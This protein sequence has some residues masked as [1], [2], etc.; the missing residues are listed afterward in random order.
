LAGGVAHDFNN[1]LTS[2]IGH[3]DLALARPTLPPEV[4]D[5]LLEVKAAG[6][7][8]AELTRQL[9]AFS[10]KQV[11]E[12]RVVELNAVIE[13]VARLLRRTIGEDVELV[14]RLAPG[15]GR[16]RADPVQLEQVFINRAVNARDA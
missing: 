2:V 13:G 12:V 16:V 6:A 1:L 7:R 4:R 11:L 14:L 9:L 8:A 15:L 10:R 5:D 3:T